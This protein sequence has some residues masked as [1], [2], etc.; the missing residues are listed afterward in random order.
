LKYYTIYKI[1]NL[2]NGHF[3]LG[4]HCTNDLND[5]Y[6]GSGILIS[7]AI[8]FYG[9]ENFR[10][11]TVLLCK[12]YKHMFKEERKIITKK[13]ISNPLCYNLITGGKRKSKN[14]VKVRIKSKAC[15]ELF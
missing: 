9:K 5:E 1:T 8:T 10:K 3:Y 15:K 6:M 11:E 7:R 4:A 2:I 14:T 13:V 12:S